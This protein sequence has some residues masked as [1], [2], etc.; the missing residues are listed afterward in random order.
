[1]LDKAVAATYKKAR[2]E[3]EKNI[4]KEGIKYGN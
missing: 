2:K 1:M 3:I 4:Y